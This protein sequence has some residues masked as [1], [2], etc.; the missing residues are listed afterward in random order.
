MP[1]NS[2]FTS[3]KQT[4][5]S[6]NEQTVLSD[7]IEES[8][9]I[10]GQEFTYIP[11]SLVSKDEILG[12]DRLSKFT[13]AYPIEMYVETPNG[14]LGQGEFV[15]KFGLY[16]EQ[17][18]QV[19]MS[20]RRWFE[21]ISRHGKTILPE[22]PAEG[23]LVYYPLT[24]RLFEIKYVEKETGF[25]QLG[26]LPLFKLT[27]ELFQYSSERIDTGVEEIDAFETLKSFSTDSAVTGNGFLKSITITNPGSGYTTAPSITFSGGNG[28]GAAATASVANG[29]VIGIT[30]TN[31]GSGYS[32][33]PI[34]IITGTGIGAQATATLEADIDIPDSYGDNRK[35]KQQFKDIS[36][37]PNNPFSE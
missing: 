36:F 18:L 3:E 1:L 4:Q 9:K 6:T 13:K 8:I 23:D 19:S 14:F 20:R 22:R 15:S 37:D 25:W 34:V 33:A 32:S 2:Y 11:R 35:F 10:W 16:I 24:K 7:L 29:Q 17:S 28:S 5:G 26:Q 31:R 30:I 27:I 12:E 21:L